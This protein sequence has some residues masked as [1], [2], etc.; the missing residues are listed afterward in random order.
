MIAASL[1]IFLKCENGCGH[2]VGAEIPCYVAAVTE[3]TYRQCL[4]SDSGRNNCGA[5]HHATQRLCACS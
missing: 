1:K 4:I 2:Q 3:P 5:K